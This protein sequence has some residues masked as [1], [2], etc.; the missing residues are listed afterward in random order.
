ML[1]K[2]DRLLD[3]LSDAAKYLKKR[4]IEGKLSESIDALKTEAFY[5]R[6]L[7]RDILDYYRNDMEAG[8]FIDDMIRLIDG[9]LTRAWNEGMRQNALDPKEDMTDEYQEILDGIISAEY[10]HVL[11][12]ASAIEAARTNEAGVNQLYVRADMWTNRYNDVVN[13]AK[14]ATAD[15]KDK[16]EWVLGETEQHCTTCAA[17]HGVVASVRQWEESGYHP[18][19]P[20]NDKLECGGWQCDCR[21]DPTRKRRTRGGIPSV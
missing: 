10:D 6:A 21:L 8:E 13:Q 17:L 12:L 3:A 2:H 18:Q 9:Q 15:D 20:P 19:Q 4:G 14:L 1:P 16:Y 11:D 5:N 7:R